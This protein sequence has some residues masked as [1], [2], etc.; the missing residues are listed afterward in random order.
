[1]NV[2]RHGYEAAR[3]DRRWVHTAAVGLLALPAILVVLSA[4][5]GTAA[6]Q[7]TRLVIT[8]TV[9]GS[10]GL[11]VAAWFSPRVVGVALLAITALG[12]LLWIGFVSAMGASDSLIAI[13]IPGFLFAVSPL[14]I[15]GSLLVWSS[16]GRRG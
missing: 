15:V 13:W 9:I 16:L 1:M 7:P 11:A 14:I 6:A 12:F 8:L 2:L 3:P 10:I 5:V 4:L